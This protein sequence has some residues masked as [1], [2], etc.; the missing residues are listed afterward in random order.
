MTGVM[1]ELVL[2]TPRVRLSF[3]TAMAEFEREGRRGA[4][5]D[6][7]LGSEIQE[8]GSSWATRGGFEEYVRW[9][10]AQALESSPRPKGYVPS[11]TLWWTDGSD[12]LGRIAIRHRLT[13]GLREVGGHI[14]YDV[15]PSARRQGHAT[16]ML[17]AALPA[18]LQLNINPVLLT[19]D[20]DNLGSRKAIERNGGFLED[21]RGDKVRYWVPTS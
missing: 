6:T 8:Y 4:G 15:R 17:R 11:T 2:P 19:C 5:D 18:A 20:T 21:Q 9:L 12:Y 16:A 7:M 3:L 10:R 14:G 13:P 1:P